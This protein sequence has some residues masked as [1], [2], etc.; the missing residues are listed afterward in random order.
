MSAKPVGGMVLLVHWLGETPD[1]PMG[2]EEAVARFL[3]AVDGRLVQDY[4]LRRSRY[5]LDRFA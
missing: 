2:G 1:Y 4:G 5:R 3:A